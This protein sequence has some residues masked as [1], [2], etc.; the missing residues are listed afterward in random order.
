M[1]TATATKGKSTAKAAART[2]RKQPQAAAPSNGRTRGKH[3][4][5]LVIVESPTKAR[6]V[7]NILGDEYEVIASVGHVRDLPPYGYGVEDIESM[8]FTPKYV[9]VKDKRRGVDK[10]EVVAEIAAAAKA[11]NRVFLSTDPDREGE[12]IAWHIKE[13]AGI[14]TEKATRVV[15]HEI[16]KPAIEAAFA[17]AMGQQ[18]DGA[19]D[20]HRKSAGKIDMDLVDAQQARRVLD[21]LIGFPLT[22]FV[23]KKVSRGAS[24]G[25]VQSV[26]LGLIVNREKEIRDFR[27]VEYWTIHAGLAKQGRAFEAELTKFADGLKGAK[28]K[29]TFTN[30]GPAIP[31]EETANELLAKLRRSQFQVASVT[32]GEKKR[33]PAPPFTTSTFQ[34]AAVN[35][36]GMSAARAMSIAQELYEGVGGQGLITYMRTD[37]LNISPIARLQ[38]RDFA[39]RTWGSEYIPSKER[40]YVTRSRGAQEAHEAIRPTNP[41][42]TPESLR[43][44]LGNDQLRVYTLIWQ[45]FMASQMS[46]ARYATVTVDIEAR[47]GATTH[48]TFRASSSTLTFEGHL[49]VYGADA[50][51]PAAGED[52][53]DGLQGSLPDLAQGD[54]L[55]QRN[56][57]GRRHQTEPPP[58]YT[59]ATLVK[60]LEEEGIGRPSTYAT[61]VQT[62][63]KRDYVEKQGRQLVPQE[64][65]FIVHDLLEQYMK[66]YVDVPF[67]GEMER[68]LDEV[69]QGDRKYEEV[70][71]EFWPEFKRELDSAEGAAEKQ[72][73]VTAIRCN[74]CNQANLVIKWGRNGKF[75]ACPRY[76]ECTNSLPM[77]PDGEPVYAAAPQEIAYRCPKDGGALVQKSGPYGQYVDCVNREKGTC[78]FRGGVPVGVA[79]PEEPETG[80][81]V[82]KQTKRGIF[83]GCW[84][85][86]HCSYTTNSLEPGKMSP[87]RPLA[88]REEANKKL[89]ERSLR[90]KA[91]FA[92]RKAGTTTTR[93][94]KAS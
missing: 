69:A 68:E 22:W 58:R 80:Q 61:I 9:V 52:E 36:L 70:L 4:P 87:A 41:A 3:A 93:A 10:T 17:E 30:A 86:P 16:T 67:T 72:Q 88:E 91:A 24:A 12:A 2:T 81:L 45:R 74:V 21:R 59:E 78:D 1:A 53:E 76:P 62:V 7:K 13:A 50:A 79:C 75:F 43:R 60:A 25:R 77:G 44:A 15:F 28:L 42:A 11:A 40:V 90:G 49:K 31:S 94:R 83:Y 89:L 64:L 84:N 35:R 56:V 14:P 82:Q 6:T 48:A 54:V 5:N 57:E 46:D 55:D 38:A 33:S 73:E 37:S 20:H 85:Y 47:E 19:A 65:G 8:N 32:R 66:K 63:L 27:P 18:V 29:P 51:E 34:Q 39:A 71:R 23:Q 92:K 26:A